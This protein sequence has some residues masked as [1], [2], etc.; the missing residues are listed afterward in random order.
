M[1]GWEKSL[2]VGSTLSTWLAL[3]TTTIQ[4]TKRKVELALKEAPGYRITSDYP[5]SI[6]IPALQE[7]DYLPGLLT[8]IEHQSYYPIE[9]IVVDSSVEESYRASER[10]CQQ[11]GACIIH[12]PDLDTPA[13]ARNEG[14]RNATG[15]IL[16]FIDADC[17]IERDYVSK[18][19]LELTKGYTVAHGVQLLA[20]GLYNFF[21]VHSSIWFKPRTRTVR[22]P[23]LWKAAFWAV[24][25]YNESCD[26]REGCFE[27]VELGR[28]IV[29]EFGNYSISLVR[30][31]CLLTSPR[32]IKRRPFERAWQV[33][34]IRDA[35]IH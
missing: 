16:I 21:S 18:M 12:R 31:A 24:G 14:A 8:S 25:G 22:G 7:E 3:A 20:N 35:V 29:R 4:T 33:R 11:Y 9:T 19:V 10:I 23:A 34:G 28:S 30:D 1:K 15:E 26:P 17:V 5:V 6:I 2:L 27:D 32:R 13:K